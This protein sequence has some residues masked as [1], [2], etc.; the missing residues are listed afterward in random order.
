M[1][2]VDIIQKK[3]DKKQFTQNDIDSVIDGVFN[4]TIPDYLITTWLMAIYIN[5]LSLEESYFLTKSMW[6]HSSYIDLRGHGK[7]VID[8]HSTGG[9]G[10]KVSLILL[11]IIASLGLPVAKI[12]G[13]G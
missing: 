4:K 9:I 12:S 7:D 5:G 10:D 3:V 2:I 11:P 8:K 6:K 1:R 13:R